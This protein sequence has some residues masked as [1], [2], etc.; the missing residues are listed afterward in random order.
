MEMISALNK[1]NITGFTQYAM[2]NKQLLML[3]YPTLTQIEVTQKLAAQWACLPLAEKMIYGDDG[4]A[5]NT[6]NRFDFGFEDIQQPGDAEEAVICA[7]TMIQQMEQPVDPTG[8]I[9]WLGSHVISQYVGAHGTLPHEL[10][11]KLS[12][13]DFVA[14]IAT[15]ETIDLGNCLSNRAVPPLEISLP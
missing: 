8:Y 9:M 12:K 2:K 7:A 11:Q 10:T 5:S 4:V 6:S 15:K 3:E 14:P 13:G 1:G